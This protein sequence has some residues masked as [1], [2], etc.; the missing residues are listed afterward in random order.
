MDSDFPDEFFIEPDPEP[1]PGTSGNPAGPAR[2]RTDMGG[3][4]EDDENIF[5]ATEATA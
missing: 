1:E 5:T 3:G 2:I 4:F